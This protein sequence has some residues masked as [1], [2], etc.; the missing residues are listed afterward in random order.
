MQ[1]DFLSDFLNCY[2]VQKAKADICIHPLNKRPAAQG[3]RAVFSVGGWLGEYDGESKGLKAI[4]I[5]IMWY[6]KMYG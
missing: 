1:R 6:R 5:Q 4:N 2:Q 3:E